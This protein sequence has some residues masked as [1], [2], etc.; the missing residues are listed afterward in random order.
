VALAVGVPAVLLFGLTQAVLP[1]LAAQR[2]RDRVKPY[3]KLE[4]VSVKA[5]PAIELLWGKAESA[6]ASAKR[7]SLS[8]ADAVKLV[9]EGR[10]VHD[11]T[12]KVAALELAVPGLPSGVVLR[13][14]VLSKRGDRLSTQ[15][16]ITQADLDAAAPSGVRARLLASAPGTVEVSA[17]GSLFGVQAT[18]EAVAMPSEGRLIARPLNIPFGAFVEMT[19]F[20]DPHLYLEGISVTPEGAGS[21]QA[22]WRLRLSGRLR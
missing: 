9:W 13:D 15:A 19:L 11:T 6:S 12:L 8:E 14:A 21:S 1:R 3:G 20:A 17:S 5:F 4:D 18:V 7:L 2:V 10:G 16:T 22:A